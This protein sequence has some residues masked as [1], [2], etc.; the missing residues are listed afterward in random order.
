MQRYP[1]I[2][3][4]ADLLNINYATAKNIV[5]K[6]KKTHLLRK[7]GNISE[8][9]RCNYKLIGESKDQTNSVNTKGG[10]VAEGLKKFVQKF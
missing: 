1:F 4:A 6:F 8:S 10:L 2:V 3:Q 9:K 7:S 5:L